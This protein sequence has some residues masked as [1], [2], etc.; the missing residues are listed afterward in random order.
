MNLVTIR[1]DEIV[2][3]DWIAQISSFLSP[4]QPCVGVEHHS[5]HGYPVVKLT[6]TCLGDDMAPWTEMTPERL[7]SVER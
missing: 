6:F 3:G 4:N 5:Y 7:V 1:A 2:E